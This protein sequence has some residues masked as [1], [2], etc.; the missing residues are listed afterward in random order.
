MVV[1]ITAG[2]PQILS[3]SRGII[4]A[5]I[6]IP[7][8]ILP[9]LSHYHGNYCGI[10]TV[11]IPMSLFNTRIVLFFAIDLFFTRIWSVTSHSNDNINNNNSNDNSILLMIFYDVNKVPDILPFQCL[12]FFSFFNLWG[13]CY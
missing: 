3:P 12:L 6:P 5:F 11:H 4:V 8:G 2:I 10:T 9:I 13:L 7:T 1:P